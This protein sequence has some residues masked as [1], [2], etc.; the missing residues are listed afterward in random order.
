MLEGTDRS[1]ASRV[2]MMAAARRELAGQ[3]L[4]MPADEVRR[5]YA[6]Q[7]GQLQRLIHSSGLRDQPLSDADLPFIAELKADLSAEASKTIGAGKLLAAMLFLFPHELPQLYEFDAIP[8]WLHGDYLDYSLVGPAIFRG[9]GEA[10]T[11]CERMSG[12]VA[13]LRERILSNVNDEFWRNAAIF[14]AKNANF[15]PFYFNRSNLR[16]L[17][18]DRSAILE[19]ALRLGNSPVDHTFG[20]R[21]EGRRLRLGILAAHFAPQTETF[22]TLPV[23]RD[24]DRTKFEVVLF[25][26]RQTNHPVE[27]SCARHADRFVV[28]PG[29]LGQRLQVLRDADLDLIF[30]GTNMTAVG[31]ETTAVAVH[32]LARIQVT[33]VCSCT[34]TGMR[35]MDYYLSGRL[36]EPADGQSHYSEKLV[37]IDGAAHC[38][39]FDGEPAVAPA[40][41]LRREAIGVAG[42]EIVF[43]SGANFYKILPEIKE[44]WMRILAAVPRSRLMLYPFNP[45]WSDAYPADAFMALFDGALKRHGIDANRLVVLSAAQSRQEVRERLRL[46]DIYLDSFPFCG[47]T[48]LLDPLAVGL[49]TIVMNGGPHRTMQGAGMLRELEMDELIVSDIEGY[50]DLATSLAKDA[51]SRDRMRDRILG[52]MKALPRFLDTKWYGEQVELAFERMCKESGLVQ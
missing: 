44:T 15:V 34:T 42:D 28:L 39:S 7:P 47:A 24:L 26:L 3:W 46:A 10:D 13:Y 18:R 14:V 40:Q 30:V 12:W 49:P 22:A 48:S 52:K 5:Q 1:A 37:M 23:Y 2:A 16:E 35:N 31:N 50:V 20:A 21:P 27:Q 4:A 41:T 6:E 36:S 33:S 17:Y 25:A 29:D 51:A 9:I 8:S 45:N 19:A 11:Y 43:V 32:R 38:F